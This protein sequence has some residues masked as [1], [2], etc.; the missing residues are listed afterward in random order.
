MAAGEAG[1]VSWLVDLRRYARPQPGQIG[2]GRLVLVVGPSGAGKDTLIA[3][4]RAACADDPTVVF[5]RRAITRLSTASE[6]HDTLSEEAFGH[7][8]AVG[9]FALWWA[10]HGHR[11]G[12]PSSIDE[13][14]R[15]GRTVVCNVSRT[16]LGLAR[17]RYVSVTVVLVTAP[18]RVLEARLAG[19]G[20]ASDGNLGDRI[21]RSASPDVSAEADVEIQ[22]V[23]RVEIGVRR[24]LN[25]IRDPGIFVAY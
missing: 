9:D 14:I 19:R 11:Y 24:L 16:V 22:N 13:D 1:C 23:G 10:A 17:Q 25:A 18:Q 8:T 12:I 5:P 15:S 3:G 6:D 20:R 4:A 21:G 7:A 2:P